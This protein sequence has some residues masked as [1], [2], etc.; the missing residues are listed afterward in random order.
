MTRDGVISTGPATGERIR[1]GAKRNRRLQFTRSFHPLSRQTGR[2]VHGRVQE[3]EQ[4][5]AGV[6]SGHLGERGAERA[7]EF[8]G[9]RVQNWRAARGGTSSPE[10]PRTFSR[11]WQKKRLQKQYA[12]AHRAV[13][14]AGTAAR[15]AEKTVQKTERVALFLRRHWKGALI[16]GGVGF[17][18][19]FFLSALQSCSVLLGGGGSNLLSS[20]YL[21][22]DADLLAAEEAY[23]AKEKELQ[24]YLDTYEATHTYDAYQFELDEIGHDPYVLLSI[25]SALHEGRFTIDEVE[26]DLQT[27]FE[28]QYRLTE[29]VTAETQPDAAGN[30]MLRTL[31][32][33]RLE[34]F[35]LSRLPVSLLN[36]TQLS[37]Y[38][39]YLSALGN[40][41]DLFP[42]SVYLE[43]YL[44]HPPED[45]EIPAEYRADE[46][47]DALIT[48][49]EQYL[50]Y[51]YVWGGSNPSTS[52]DC[53][54]FVCYVL[55]HSGLCDTGRLSAQGLYDLSTPVTD[56]RPGDLVFFTGTY[57]TPGVSH[58]GIYVGDG[59]MLHCGDPIQYSSL[60]TSYWQSHFYAY[61]RPP[62]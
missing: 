58:V 59:M 9:R 15:A 51:P 28:Q 34:N 23:C 24:T 18:L 21:S 27:L 5:N 41:P 48:E 10:P 7:V 36:E 44:E 22:A 30:P 33:V 2:I 1:Q 11:L 42:S 52:F 49:A 40:R 3:T 6:Q 57:D 38:A 47:F 14:K 46:R 53:S 54:G 62:Y 43:R 31:C 25:L 20:T 17:L 50:G 61:G 55:T 32:T 60:N 45:W 29:T 26:D 4:E 8:T 13:D 19:L 35:D 39:G 16:A 12:A 56:P 37:G